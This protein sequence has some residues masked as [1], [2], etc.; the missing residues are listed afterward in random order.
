M[1]DPLVVPEQP[2]V[3]ET[4]GFLRRF[5]DLMSTGY[6]A[7]YLHRAADL[8]ENLTVRV[9][10]AMDE[11]QLWRYKYETTIQHADALEAEC[12]ALKH[13]IDGHLEITSS[14]LSERNALKAALE[15]RE[16]ELSE[17]SADLS[18]AHSELA[19][20]AEV[21]EKIQ[22]GLGAAF[23]R[24]REALKAAALAQAEELDQLRTTLEREREEFRAAVKSGEADRAELRLAFD[25]ERA[26]FRIQLKVRDDELAALRVT[27]QREYDALKLKVASLEAR[28]AELR[29]T[30]ERISGLRD[31]TIEHQGGADHSVSGDALFE[32][33]A[34]PLAAQPGDLD[35]AFAE[36]NAVVPRT[37]L[38]Q[39]R[40][41]F[42]HL[43][44]EC[45]SRGDIA[46]QVMCQLGAHS[47]E[48]ALTAG[49]KT[50]SLPVGEVALRI[51]AA[52]AAR[53]P[54]ITGT[55]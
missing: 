1:T 11:E 17:L 25:R 39:A 33:E 28:R 27:Y 34:T 52:E 31:Q 23:D 55:M 13:D 8:L 2:D 9:I 24:E 14:V 45:I 49:A 35:P 18:R 29:S 37:V 26:E 22:A 30:F 46:S 5:A 38:R 4:A 20:K 48:L 54:V 40:A 53:T 47:L 42:E 7:T 36:A 10:A 51:L 6:N 44:K 32:A 43:A 15:Q 50:E 21:N 41:Q 12:D 3:A 16:A 19:T